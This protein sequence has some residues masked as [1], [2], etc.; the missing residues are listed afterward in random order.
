MTSSEEAM[1]TMSSAEAVWGMFILVVI[2][3]IVLVFFCLMPVYRALMARYTHWDD[4]ENDPRWNAD[5]FQFS[6]TSPRLQCRDANKYNRLSVCSNQTVSRGSSFRNTCV[7]PRP[8]DQVEIKMPPAYAD[9]FNTGSG[10]VS[11]LGTPP[12]YYSHSPSDTEDNSD[13]TKPQQPAKPNP[14]ATKSNSAAAATSGEPATTAAAV[15]AAPVRKS[16][17]KVKKQQPTA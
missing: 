5:Q 16:Y 4:P 15:A 9:I 7:L 6:P 3:I 10:D 1:A 2:L 8:E 12:A 14:P 17:K 13:Q 11:S